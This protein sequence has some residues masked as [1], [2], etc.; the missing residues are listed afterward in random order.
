MLTVSFS[1]KKWW[2]ILGL[3]ILNKSLLFVL[4]YYFW[5]TFIVQP[6][7]IQVNVAILEGTYTDDL[8]PNCTRT[9]DITGEES[10]VITGIDAKSDAVGGRGACNHFDDFIW[11][12]HGTFVAKAGK[13]TIEADFTEKDEQ[14]NPSNATHYDPDTRKRLQGIFDPKGQTIRWLIDGNHWRKI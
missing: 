11:T 4:F 9:I 14:Q 5:I 12:I 7:V 1:N 6:R 3:I 8:H 10:F 13:I 2:H